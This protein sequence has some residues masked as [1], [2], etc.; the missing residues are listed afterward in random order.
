VLDFN[1]GEHDRVQLDPGTAY[2]VAQV[3][4]DTV[5]SLGNGDAMILVGV[6]LGSLP[7]GWIFQA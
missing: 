2:S 6:N 5:I 7:A 3:G 4:S 1:A